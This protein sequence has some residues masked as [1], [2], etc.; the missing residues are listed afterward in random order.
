MLSYRDNVLTLDQ[1]AALIAS[2]LPQ[3][4]VA[5]TN[6]LPVSLALTA[7]PRKHK[8]SRPGGTR[9]TTPPGGNTGGFPPVGQR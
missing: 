4:P 8:R 9:G 6:S 1:A 5:T 7:P 2:A 3:P